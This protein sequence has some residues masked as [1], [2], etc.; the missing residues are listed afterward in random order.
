MVLFGNVSLDAQNQFYKSL[1]GIPKEHHDFIKDAA[2]ALK[3]KNDQ[4]TKYQGAAIENMNAEIFDKQEEPKKDFAKK[5]ALGL[6]K[7]GYEIVKSKTLDKMP[8]ATAIPIEVGLE[9]LENVYELHQ[10]R[11]EYYEAVERISGENS[12]VDIFKTFR[13]DIVDSYFSPKVFVDEIASQFKKRKTPQAQKEF[14]DNLQKFNSDNQIIFHRDEVSLKMYEMLIRAI[15]DS[16]SDGGGYVLLETDWS[17]CTNFLNW[18]SN[19]QLEFC[20]P[21]NYSVKMVGAYGEKIMNRVNQLMIANGKKSV[22]DLNIY[23]YAKMRVNYNGCNKC[24]IVAPIW[25]PTQSQ[26]PSNIPMSEK[27]KNSFRKGGKI[28]AMEECYLTFGECTSLSYDKHSKWLWQAAFWGQRNKEKF[29]AF[30]EV[31]N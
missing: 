16:K 27:I 24:Y 4:L 5:F 11:K 26:S 1:E 17:T 7:S 8:P 22:F 2:L 29:T 12:V 30:G 31:S 25:L 19:S 3:F 14:L 10:N 18:S 28:P 23:M 21:T 6:A 20:T 15:H 9:I 13:F